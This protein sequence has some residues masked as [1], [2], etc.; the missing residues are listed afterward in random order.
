[1]FVVLGWRERWIDRWARRPTPEIKLPTRH[2]RVPLCVSG[3]VWPHPDSSVGS[4]TVSSVEC[5]RSIRPTSI[6]LHQPIPPPTNTQ[7]TTTQTGLDH[8]TH[9]PPPPN[10][11]H[12][13]IK[14]TPIGLAPEYGGRASG[15][16][17]GP[18]RRVGGRLWRLRR[19]RGCVGV[20]MYVH[21]SGWRWVSVGCGSMVYPSFVRVARTSSGINQ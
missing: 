11:T 18:R 8:P 20:C 4:H 1:M 21:V 17:G 9:Q 7:K 12:T 16:A 13:I 10:H 19:A 5:T 14:Q 6:R 15:G 3:V 2:A